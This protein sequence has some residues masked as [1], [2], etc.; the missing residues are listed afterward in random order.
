MIDVA[1]PFPSWR[2]YRLPLVGLI[3]A[4]WLILVVWAATPYAGLLDHHQIEEGAFPV[5]VRWSAFL[6]GWTLMVLAMMLPGSLPMLKSFVA[7]AATSTAAP[8]RSFRWFVLGYLAVWVAFGAAV[9]LGDTLLHAAVDGGLVTDAAA[10]R[11]PVVLLLAAG[12]YQ[13]T[14]LRRSCHTQCSLEQAPVNAAGVGVLHRGLSAGLL[15]LGTCGAT[16]L[17]MF[18]LGGG[19]N[20]GWMV[21]LTAITLLERTSEAGRYVAWPLGCV[22]VLWAALKLTGQVA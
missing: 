15:C 19:V 8:G 6:A 2:V 11:I 13:F 3:V 5:L 14:P 21:G 12:L 17:L 18:A 4:A 1:P 7:A 10:D 9:Y 16:M 22:L 20:L